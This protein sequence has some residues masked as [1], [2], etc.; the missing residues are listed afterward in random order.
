MQME[1]L[2]NTTP[3][4][5]RVILNSFVAYQ[6]A[7]DF[8]ERYNVHFKITEFENHFTVKTNWLMG[9]VSD[10][11]KNPI[12]QKEDEQFWNYSNID[13]KKSASLNDLAKI[14]FSEINNISDV[15]FNDNSDAQMNYVENTRAEGHLRD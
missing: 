15:S 7:L 12:Y 6:I 1:N 11:E 9:E 2:K 14:M 10:T 8:D 5:L 13:V 3:E 4:Q